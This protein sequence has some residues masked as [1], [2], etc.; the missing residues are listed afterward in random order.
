MAFLKSS[1]GKKRIENTLRRS[2]W[3]QKLLLTLALALLTAPVDAAELTLIHM[4]DIHGHL[5]PRPSARGETTATTEGG[6]A[7]I[8]AKIEEIR[9]QRTRARTLLINTGDT[10]QGSAE[11]L[12]T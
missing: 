8:Y 12:F 6:L 5:V 10:I 3:S 11:A 7:R 2:I 9:T 1:P 4:G